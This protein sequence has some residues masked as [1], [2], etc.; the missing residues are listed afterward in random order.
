M[1]F[2][3]NSIAHKVSV[4]TFKGTISHKKITLKVLSEGDTR[5]SRI[6]HKS[7]AVKII[8]VIKNKAFSRYHSRFVV[9]VGHET[10]YASRGYKHFF[11]KSC[12]C[13]TYSYLSNKRTC[14]L[15]LFKNKVQPTLLAPIFNF[16]LSTKNF[17]W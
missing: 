5:K 13:Q 10:M 6:L 16:D 4:N 9:R 14:P 17:N 12:H 3:K 15:I 2:W 8:I 7:L 11:T 1:T